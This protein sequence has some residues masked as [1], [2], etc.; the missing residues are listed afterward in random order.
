MMSILQDPTAYV[1]PSVTTY[2]NLNPGYRVY[3]VDGVRINST[4]HVLDHETY[5]LDLDEANRTNI[6]NWK[7]EYSAK[8]AYD[9]KSLF[10][11]DWNDL[12]SRMMKNET[13]FN[14]FFRNAYKQS[15]I[16]KTKCGKACRSNWI[17]DTWSARSGDPKL[18]SSIFSEKQYLN[19]YYSS[20]KKHRC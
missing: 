18:C 4:F 12:S 16:S 17:C 13:L 1:S 10:P 11:E 15:P 14:K 7:K 3:T 5:Y 20:F 9:M 19:Y 8:S 2:P 6:P